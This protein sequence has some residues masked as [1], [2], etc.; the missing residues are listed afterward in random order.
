MQEAKAKI[1]YDF[2]LDSWQGKAKV[3]GTRHRVEVKKPVGGE[4]TSHS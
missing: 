2:E 3:R 1:L 4:R